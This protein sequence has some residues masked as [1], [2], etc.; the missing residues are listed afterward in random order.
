MIRKTEKEIRSIIKEELISV[1]QE[2]NMFHN[3]KGHFTSQDKATSYSI[4][5]AANIK[6][7]ELVKKAKVSG[8]KLSY[9][10]G[11]PEKCG[12]KNISGNNISPKQSCSQ[13]PKRYYRKDADK[14]VNEAMILGTADIQDASI[15]SDQVLCI[16]IGDIVRVL[17]DY[18]NR[19][20]EEVSPDEKRCFA[21][22]Y[23]K[24]NINDI[25]NLVSNFVDASNGE[26]GK[27]D[28]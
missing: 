17:N 6:D 22:G 10:F 27:K 5:N 19:M 28:K 1:L 26:F 20:N 16:N 8:G 7:K 12:R 3:S 2:A 14:A 18:N 21:L 15:N 11:L 25:M 9:R 24:L 13:F 23:R 4:T